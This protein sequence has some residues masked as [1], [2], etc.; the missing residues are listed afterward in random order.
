VL[1]L[2]ILSQSKFMCRKSLRG[3]TDPTNC[4][5]PSPKAPN[6]TTIGTGSLLMSHSNIPSQRVEGFLDLVYRNWNT[7]QSTSSSPVW[8]SIPALKLSL[9]WWTQQSFMVFFVIMI[10]AGFEPTSALWKTCAPIQENSLPPAA[11]LPLHHNPDQILL[12]ITE[13]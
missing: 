4:E 13:Y 8:T 1:P 7:E 9:H 5:I 2:Y 12:L 11:V 6:P 10:R 3:D